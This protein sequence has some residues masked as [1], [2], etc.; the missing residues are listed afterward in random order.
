M[1]NAELNVNEREE[2]YL[3]KDIE[4]KK[5]ESELNENIGDEKA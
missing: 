5:V 3:S 2:K 1:F 4:N